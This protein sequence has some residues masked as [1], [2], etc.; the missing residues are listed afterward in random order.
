MAV[1]FKPQGVLVALFKIYDI[2]YFLLLFKTFGFSVDYA[3]IGTAMTGIAIAL[4]SNLV[5]EEIKK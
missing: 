2:V 3:T 4:C 5:L 1:L